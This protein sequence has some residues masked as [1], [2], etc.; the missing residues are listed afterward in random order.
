MYRS[1]YMASP[2]AYGQ[3]VTIRSNVIFNGGASYSADFGMCDLRNVRTRLIVRA[4]S[5]GGSR[6]GKTVISALG[7]SDATS[8]EVGSGC[9]RVSSGMTRIGVWQLLMNS[10]GTL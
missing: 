6:N 8:I 2:H 1:W 3:A 10:R 9:D 5:S 7:A 4:L